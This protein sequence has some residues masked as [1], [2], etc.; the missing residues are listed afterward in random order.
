MKIL[1]T[2]V[3][4]LGAAFL[5]VSCSHFRESSF[6]A[7]SDAEKLYAK[8]KY[9]AAMAKYQLYLK[10]NP[11]G[12]MAAIAEYSI[13]KCYG[14]LK[15]P[16]AARAGFEKV[17]KDYPKTSWAEFSQKQLETLQASSK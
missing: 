15:K 6:G 5:F 11:E 3:V 10:E 13:A 9:E 1:K 8:G 14:M 12:N 4:L 17:I 7:Y 16:E 2:M